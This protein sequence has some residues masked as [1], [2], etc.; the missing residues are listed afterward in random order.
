MNDI[1]EPRGAAKGCCAAKGCQ[2]FLGKHAQLSCRSQGV[3][4]RGARG[5]WGSTAAKGCAGSQGVPEVSGEA[6]AT[7]PPPGR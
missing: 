5:F 7:F 6:R 4:P 2:R 1:P 3:Q